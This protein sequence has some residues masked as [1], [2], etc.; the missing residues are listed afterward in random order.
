MTLPQRR[1]R[2][3]ARAWSIVSLFLLERYRLRIKPRDALLWFCLL[4]G[5]RLRGRLVGARDA[6]DAALLH[7]EGLRPRHVLAL[8]LDV[9]VAHNAA[10]SHRAL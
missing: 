10:R 5:P 2:R 8:N 3:A 9:P 7:E 4:G 1:F 6:L